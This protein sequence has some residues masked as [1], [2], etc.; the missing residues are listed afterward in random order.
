MRQQDELYHFGILGMKWGIRR[1]QNEDGTRT[2]AGK[3]RY[4]QS[5]DT[6]AVYAKTKLAYQE[7][8]T[9][10]E[11]LYK[12]HDKQVS[13]II[14]RKIPKEEVEAYQKRFK[15]KLNKKLKED[16]GNDYRNG[17]FYGDDPELFEIAL[18]ERTTETIKE[19]M[20][21]DGEN[22][23][24]HRDGV[25]HSDDFLEHHGILGMKWGIRRYQNEDGSYT[26]AGKRRKSKGRDYDPD[27]WK[28][29]DK[30][31]VEYMSDKELQQ[32]INRMNNENQY[33]QL[34]KSPAR[35]AAEQLGKRFVDKVIV[36]A[37]IG[38]AAIYV[39]KHSPEI[40][41][42]GKDFAESLLR[43]DKNKLAGWLV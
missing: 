21:E 43:K 36:S 14:S 19:I 39:K 30:K 41:N 8:R 12:E 28:A 16:F 29:H 7:S 2:P 13:E 22:P 3:K 31:K 35:K 4:K 23:F 9:N 37:A 34:S 42:A 38:A 1:F 25:K 6:G 24:P 11:K 20:R 26:E 5:V 32:R 17:K 33:K 27:Y 40:L 10:L 15:K 18:E